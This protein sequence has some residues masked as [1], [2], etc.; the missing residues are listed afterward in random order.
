MKIFASIEMFDSV[1][2]KKYHPLDV[3]KMSASIINEMDRIKKNTYKSERDRINISNFNSRSI[4]NNIYGQLSG[5]RFSERAF[6]LVNI[7]GGEFSK[8]ITM[9]V[10]VEI[11][12]EIKEYDKKNHRSYT[13]LEMYMANFDYRYF[14]RS[15][16]EIKEKLKNILSY[17]KGET[18]KIQL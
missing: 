18:Q 15:D 10:P 13:A 11:S 7:C 4:S 6:E 14:D 8:S 17:I 5:S 1:P 9:Y 12:F 3:K 2:E 16:L